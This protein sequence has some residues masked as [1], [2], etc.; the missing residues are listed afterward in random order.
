MVSQVIDL[1]DTLHAEN[2][3]EHFKTQLLDIHQL[4]DY[5]K[6]NLLE[7]GRKFV[8]PRGM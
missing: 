2:Q 3:Y 4:S 6:F 1:V 7:V 5:K 8:L